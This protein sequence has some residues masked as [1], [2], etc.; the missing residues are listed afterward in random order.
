MSAAPNPLS[1][2]PAKLAGLTSEVPKMGRA[3]AACS[4]DS[5][6]PGFAP[7]P[8]LTTLQSVKFSWRLAFSKRE[9]GT[10]FFF[11]QIKDDEWVGLDATVSIHILGAWELQPSALSIPQNIVRL[12]SLPTF[13]EPNPSPEFAAAYKPDGAEP[14]KT[15]F[16]LTGDANQNIFAVSQL[17]TGAWS[18]RYS[19]TGV[20]GTTYSGDRYPLSA[21][22][23]LSFSLKRWADAGK[24]LASPEP[25][26]LPGPRPSPAQELL[27]TF[28]EAYGTCCNILREG[29]P[30]PDSAFPLNQRYRVAEYK[31]IL[32][33]PLTSSGSIAK[34]SDE[35]TAR[36]DVTLDA[37]QG[38]PTIATAALSNPNFIKSGKE[39]D[40]LMTD[41]GALGQVHH[42]ADQLGKPLVVVTAFVASARESSAIFQIGRTPD[43]FRFLLVLSGEMQGYPTVVV[44]IAE[45]NGI[46][47]S[48]LAAWP[49]DG[50]PATTLIR[51]RESAKYF[52]QLLAKIQFWAQ[53]LRTW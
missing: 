2:L 37:V 31:A 25:V 13:L 18:L 3:F 48:V 21:F 43:G 10:L 30:A 51:Y 5:W 24:A 29:F 14:P 34:D 46:F 44:A 20:P 40:R 19:P 16:L 7:L 28:A 27:D 4:V 17:E 12:A 49:Y 50:D 47:Q 23:D 11:L 1:A 35:E 41:L 8:L 42:L 45:Y 22:L 32:S 39:F 33:I 36:L 53:E 6:S 38:D 9:T 15:L 52:F 26:P